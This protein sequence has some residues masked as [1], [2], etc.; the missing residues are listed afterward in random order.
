MSGNVMQCAVFV[1]HPS[2]E[3]VFLKHFYGKEETAGVL[4]NLEV[5]IMP[6]FCI[7]EHKHDDSSEF[8]YVISG[9]GIFLDDIDW[10][11][12]KAG[13]A[14]KAPKGVRHAIKN[15]GS[16]LLRLF[17]TFSLPIR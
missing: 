2:N 13:D 9:Q 6:G 1:R 7:A 4:N 5:N 12:I 15:N 10:V 14:F 8:F 11:P 16:E 17:S 3:G